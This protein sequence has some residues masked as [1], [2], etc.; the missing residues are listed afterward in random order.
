M[1]TT[2]PL[3]LYEHKRGLA[4]ARDERDLFFLQPVNCTR[5]PNLRNCSTLSNEQKPLPSWSLHSSWGMNEWNLWSSQKEVLRATFFSIWM[6]HRHL[7]FHIITTWKH[8]HP[9]AS[10]AW[11][12]AK[13]TCRKHSM[14]KCSTRQWLVPLLSGGTRWQLSYLDHTS[15]SF[16]NPGTLPSESISGIQPLHHRCHLPDLCYHHSS[17]GQ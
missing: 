5:W 6:S 17:P 10:P 8:S 1:K 4:E 7:K 14:T 3:E 9:P 12:L 13:Q 15:N 2:V 11:C 16:P